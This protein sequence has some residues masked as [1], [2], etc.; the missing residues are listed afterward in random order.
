MNSHEE[1]SVEKVDPLDLEVVQT[2]PG[3]V[4][5]LSSLPKTPILP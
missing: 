5:L 2:P 4:V 3:L 1:R